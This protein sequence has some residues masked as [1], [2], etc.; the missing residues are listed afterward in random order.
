MRNGI[1]EACANANIVI[2]LDRLAARVADHL[3]D[4]CRSTPGMLVGIQNDVVNFVFAMDLCG[5]AG[6]RISISSSHR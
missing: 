6:R 5:G 2:D 1:A 3:F 4:G